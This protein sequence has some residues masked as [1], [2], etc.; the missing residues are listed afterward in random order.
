MLFVNRPASHEYYAIR[1]GGF[2][3]GWTRTDVLSDSFS[4][5]RIGGGIRMG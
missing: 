4:F 3:D 5:E 2:I 1:G